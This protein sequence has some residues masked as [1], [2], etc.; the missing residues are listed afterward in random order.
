MKLEQL[1]IKD[2]LSKAFQKQSL[3]RNNIE[4]LKTELTKLFGYIDENQDEDYH[5]NLIADFLK[6][7]YYRDK[8]IIN[9]NK[10]QDLVIRLG[11]NTKDKVGIILEFKKPSESR[12]MISYDKP[13]SKAFQQL[14][15]W[16]IKMLPVF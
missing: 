7:V 12:E 11:N 3:K 15:F 16:R 1:H 4:L 10:E 9:V 6:S 14:I 5:K 2:S 13:N 8:Y